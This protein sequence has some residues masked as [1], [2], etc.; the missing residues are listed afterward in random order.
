MLSLNIDSSFNHLESLVF[1]SIEPYMLSSFLAKL[2]D[3]PRL[4]SLTIDTQ[5]SLNNLTDVYRFI[6]NLSKLKYLRLFAMDPKHTGLTISLPM[7][8]NKQFSNIKYLII[9]HPCSFKELFSIISYTSQIIRLSFI[10][11]ICSTLENEIVSPMILSNLTDICIY[12]AGKT[13]NQF[14]MFITKIY[15]K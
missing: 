7:N 2:V 6:F 15:S 11:K 3:L 12:G 9:D 14:E 13:F 5:K 10:H 8:I 1:Y 4:F